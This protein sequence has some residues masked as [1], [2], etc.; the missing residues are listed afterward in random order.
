[1]LTVDNIKEF[2]DHQAINQALGFQIYFADPYCSWQRGNN[3]NFYGLLRQN[4]PKRRR[5]ETVT[6]EELSLIENRLNHQHRKRLGF[7]ASYKVFQASLNRL[8]VRTSISH[9]S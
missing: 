1:M 6:D 9:P 5:L 4:I 8:A 3:E 7:R 2:A